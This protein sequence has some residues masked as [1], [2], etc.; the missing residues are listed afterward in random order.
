MRRSIR[1]LFRGALII[2]ELRALRGLASGRV[3]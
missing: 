1:V 3:E 2:H